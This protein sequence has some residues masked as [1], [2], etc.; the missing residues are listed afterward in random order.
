MPRPSTP[1]LSPELIY[2]TA[3]DQLD[4]TGRLNMPELAGEL[5]VSVSS[6]YHHV[7]GRKG[8]LEGVRGMIADWDCG[9]PDDW[10]DHVRRWARHYRDAFAR[11]AGAIP[12][13]VGQSISDPATLR[14]YDLLAA[15]LT[16][17]GF[18]A[19]SVVLSVSILDV[20]CL[21]A[22]LDA[23]APSTVWAT[24][25]TPGSALQDVIADS[26][27]THD[28][29]RTAFELQLDWVIAGMRDRLATDQGRPRRAANRGHT[30]RSSRR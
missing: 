5:G 30:E 23:S 1:R 24:S 27:L 9:N 6:L 19:Q 15:Q 4:R 26:G 14:Q 16:E 18:S 28:R 22:A 8:V 29:S 21:G 25:A 17:A 2:R 13:L 3:L 7:D 12:A 20:L 10:V 11:H